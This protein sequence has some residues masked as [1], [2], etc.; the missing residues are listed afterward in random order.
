MATSPSLTAAG[1]TV[2][3]LDQVVE[4]IVENL[5]ASPHW[6]VKV[7][8]GVDS[9]I[10]Q[11][12]RVFAGQI[13][14]VYDLQQLQHAAFDPREAEGVQQDNLCQVVGVERT[15]ATY[16]TGT[17]TLSG[18]A[19]TVIA[20]GKRGRVGTDGPIVEL[21]AAATIG[22]G[23]TV[24]AAATAVEAGAVEIGAGAVDSIYDAVS[25]W[26]GITNAAAFT[27][28]EPQESAAT[29]EARRSRSFSISGACTYW[30]MRARLEA[31]DIVTAAAVLVNT[32]DATDSNG[33]PPHTFR[34]VVWPT[35]LDAE[36]IAATIWE[37]AGSPAGIAS[38]GTESYYVTDAKQETTH[39]V[40]WSE[41]DEQVMYVEL[42]LTTTPDYPATGDTLAAAAAVAA[43]EA[44]GLG[45][46][47]LI[48]KIEAA[49]VDAVPGISD[50]ATRIK[51][52]AG[53]SWQSTSLTIAADKIATFDTSHVTVIS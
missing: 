40:Q 16:S 26:T 14:E 17:V 37:V 22:G 27:S 48:A 30:A 35:G 41:A 51:V 53:G 34:P 49:V 19:A 21:D 9:P 5:Q 31:L 3:T 7:S 46:D 6:G 47:V 39:E 42:T 20:A 18:T 28:G 38:D 4:N 12:I 25:G 2:L 50:I 8:Y 44:L 45:A 29:L 33:L 1:L 10:G 23:G 36:T 15:A 32:T 11:L 43:G 13:M 24:D 52:T